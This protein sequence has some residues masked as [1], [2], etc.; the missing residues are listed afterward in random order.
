MVD[1]VSKPTAVQLAIYWGDYVTWR[2]AWVSA[3]GQQVETA[4]SLIAHASL[5]IDLQNKEGI[6]VIPNDQ[7]QYW[8]DCAQQALDFWTWRDG[9]VNA[10]QAIPAIA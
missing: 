8:I 2:N 6:E 7:I 9:T 3:E 5:L 4:K 1:T 10:I